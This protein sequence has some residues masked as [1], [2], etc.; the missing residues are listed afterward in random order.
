MKKNITKISVE[1]C[2]VLYSIEISF[3][4]QLHDYGLLQLSTTGKKR[5][6]KNEQLNDLEKFARFYYDLE[7]NIPGIEAIT[8]LLNRIEGLQHEIKQLKS[9]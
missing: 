9:Y 4:E 7:I 3:V 5:F 6:I 2:S 1:E 8:H